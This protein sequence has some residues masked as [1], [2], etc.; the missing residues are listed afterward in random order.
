MK[1]LWVSEFKVPTGFARV[2]KSIVNRLNKKHEITVLDW[3]QTKASFD[4]GVKVIG[5]KDEKDEFGILQ[6]MQVYDEYDAIFIL[7]D[8]WNINKY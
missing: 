6:L 1:I 2:S 5:K 3:Y 4:T 8:V 7:N